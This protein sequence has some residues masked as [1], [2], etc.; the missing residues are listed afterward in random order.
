MKKPKTRYVC[1]NCGYT[2]SKWMGQCPDCQ[3]W[4]S[5]LEEQV[6]VRRPS[7]NFKKAESFT[8]DQISNIEYERSPVG[9]EEFDRVLGGGLV[10]GE[11]VLLSGEPGIGKS[12]LLLQIASSFSA[13]GHK[14][15]YISA[16]ESLGQQRMRAQRLGIRSN[17][18]L[19]FVSETNLQSIIGYLHEQAADLVILDSV[20]AVYDPALTSSP[21][22]VSQVRETA[23]RLT[24]FGKRKQ[25]AVILVGHVTKQ[26]ISA[27]PKTLEHMVDCVLSFEGDRHHQFR[28]IR[29]VKNRFGSTQEIGLFEMKEGGLDQI[30]DPSGYLLSER[31][32]DASGSVISV[33]NE[34]TRAILV[35]IQALVIPTKYGIPKRLSIGYDL[36]RVFMLISVLEKQGGFLLSNE[37]IF[38]NVIG[39]IKVRETSLDLAI[40]AAMISSFRNKRLNPGAVVLGEVGLTGEVRSIIRMEQRLIQAEKLGFSKFFIPGANVDSLK[41][42]RN[43]IKIKRVKDLIEG[44]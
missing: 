9:V 33:I 5:L 4:N 13:A 38:I 44:I 26:G 27:G 39:G 15:I 23:Y 22:T 12:T 20:Q 42:K 19:V 41:G 31:P 28:M 3:E 11:I 16:E 34:G 32:E 7:G 36:Q 10:P 35:E 37:D 2:T 40:S 17:E 29:P 30:S 43:V 8:L 14:V 1:R 6:D 18:H 25:A 21:G 24:E